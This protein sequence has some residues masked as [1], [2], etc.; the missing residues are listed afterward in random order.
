MTSKGSSPVVVGISGASGSILARRTIDRL[1]EL[2]IPV[3]ATCS[4]AARQVWQEEM[5]VPF[6]D[7]LDEWLEHPLFTYYPIGDMRAPLASG[8]YASRG[9][10][11]VPCSMATL[12]A[13]A[14]GLTTT[15]L[16]RAADV[17]IK[18]GRKLV[19]VPRETPLSAIHLENMLALARLGATIL[20]PEPAFYLHPK[21][22][23]DV[24]E[25]I[26][27]RGLVA[28]GVLPS[29]GQGMSYQP[30]SE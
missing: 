18:E 29:M 2:E 16:H 4:N 22:I 3:V 21:T 8:T 28:A 26:V 24:V 19:L 27:Q 6:R 23:E 13:I 10:I 14:H 1:L 25:F 9:M 20:S 12:A 11:V 5:Q 17:C 15:L 7:V 30:R